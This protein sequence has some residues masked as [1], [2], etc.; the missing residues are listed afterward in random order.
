MNETCKNQ[1]AWQEGYGAFTIGISQRHH[2]VAYIE[3]QAQH[4]QRRDF[5]QEFLAFLKKNGVEY[6]PK[7]VWG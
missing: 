4:H 7:Y 3:S 5:Q 6:D 2:T 1:F